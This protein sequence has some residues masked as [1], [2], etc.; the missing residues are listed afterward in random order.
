MIAPLKKTMSSK[1]HFHFLIVNLTKMIFWKHFFFVYFAQMYYVFLFTFVQHVP[2]LLA[3]SH[4]HL[5]EQN[6][7]QG[8]KIC[9]GTTPH[10]HVLE[11][12]P[13]NVVKMHV[14]Q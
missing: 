5:I 2:F 8:N 4:V 11:F 1:H 14:L 10:Y 13:S 9:H 7:K 12:F 3:P 6:V